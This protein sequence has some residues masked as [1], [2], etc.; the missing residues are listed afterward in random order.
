MVGDFGSQGLKAKLPARKY[1][2]TIPFDRD[3]LPGDQP[4]VVQY[5]VRLQEDLDCGGAYIKLVSAYTEDD[6]YS[7]FDPKDLGEETPYAIMFGPDRCGVTDKVHFIIR[8]KNPVSGEWSEHH[9]KN[10]PKSVKDTYSHLYTLIIRPDNTFFVLIDG[11]WRLCDV[12]VL[13]GDSNSI[14]CR[15]GKEARISS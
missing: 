13:L 4:F 5:E 15:G 12:R 1:G 14:R 6:E 11:R 3:I 2:L 10:P 7:R 8:H 9:M